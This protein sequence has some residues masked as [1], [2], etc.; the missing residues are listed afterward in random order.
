MLVDPSEAAATV[1]GLTTGTSGWLEPPL[2]PRHGL[3]EV[4]PA[5]RPDCAWV[6]VEGRVTVWGER[7]SAGTLDPVSSGCWPFLDGSVSLGELTEDVAA[8]LGWNDEIARCHV[9]DLARDAQAG[10]L[11]IGAEAL[12]PA[13]SLPVAPAVRSTAPDERPPQD[14]PPGEYH[15]VIDGVKYVT[16]VA[17]VTPGTLQEVLDG[18]AFPA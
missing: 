11:L 13:A 17:E 14:R 18:T 12:V 7:A 4:R 8:A 9:L 1:N 6:T 3:K 16:F 10:G 5:I 15:D 2:G